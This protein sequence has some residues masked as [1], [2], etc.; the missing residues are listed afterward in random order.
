M[1]QIWL[2]MSFM[3]PSASLG[4]GDGDVRRLLGWMA[5]FVTGCL[6]ELIFIIIDK[7][8]AKLSGLCSGTIIECSIHRG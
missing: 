8:P 2:V 3:V 6:D 4:G 1:V 5:M 7:S